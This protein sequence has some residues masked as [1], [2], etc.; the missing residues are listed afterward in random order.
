MTYFEAREYISSLTSRGIV[1]GLDA[2]S[3]L[4]AALGDPQDDLNIIHIA[5]T[6]GKG[7]VCVFTETALMHDG[8][9][10]C[11]FSSP[12]VGDYL[13]MFTY[14]G[15]PVNE[16]LYAR[17]AADIK[18][19]AQGLE[20]DGVFPTS[21]EAETA[22]AFLMFSRLKPDYAIIECGMGG[23]LDA[24]NVI[25]NSIVSVITSISSD[26]TAFLGGTIKEIAQNKAGIIKPAGI[27]VSATQPTEA[28]E[29]IK[30]AAAEQ[31]AELYFVG[32][33]KNIVY[34]GDLTE[35]EYKNDHCAIK[36]LG[37]CQPQNAALAIEAA[38]RLGISRTAIK[39]GLSSA[40]LPFRFERIGKF[41]LD[42]A[43]NEGAARMLA[44]SLELYTKPEKTAFI[45]GCFRDK[46]YKSIAELT[47]PF[48]AAVYCIKPPT[49]RGLPSAGLCRAFKAA[50][51]EAHDCGDM[52]TAI[53]AAS[54]EEY[55][56]IIIFGSLSI[57]K[58][59]R[60]IIGDHYGES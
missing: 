30:K 51:A 22:A 55:D 11:R 41:I 42:G 46:D 50:G 12:A 33:I 16:T 36:M 14:N 19:A 26:H 57:L 34:H 7:S 9:S 3:R 15:I 23:A 59:A 53:D 18:A 35:F 43:H 21:F 25:K 48:A 31:S 17:A 39:N 8:K 29:V 6:N 45:C 5:G 27:V 10:V 20:A 54:R 13:E 4:L 38:S 58:E 28:A 56:H 52:Y 24:T 47:A 40:W 44:K 49:E 37:A 2:V 1:P 60:D 32:D